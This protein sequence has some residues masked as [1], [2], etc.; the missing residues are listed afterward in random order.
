MLGSDNRAMS[1][2]EQLNKSAV[3]L[4]SKLKY[5]TKNK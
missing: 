3:K 5:A 2:L 4:Y 1:L